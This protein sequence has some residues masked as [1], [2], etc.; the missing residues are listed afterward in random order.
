MPTHDI[1][2]NRNERLADHI[3]R[4]LDSTEAARFAVGYFFLSGLTSI[5]E[6]LA[7]VK[8]LR[9]LIGNTTNR[10]TL[11]QMAE[12]YRRLE[13]VAETAEAQA[14]PKRAD[15]KNM[16]AETAEKV[17]IYLTRPPI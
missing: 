3:N 6:K 8:E 12:G 4:I 2:D 10:E 14:Y 15:T 1:I 7:G 13:L 9:L 16:V 11:E 5:G 17:I